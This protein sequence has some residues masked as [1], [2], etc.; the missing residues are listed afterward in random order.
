MMRTTHANIS[1]PFSYTHQHTASASTRE[2]TTT[3]NTCKGRGGTTGRPSSAEMMGE[4]VH[5]RT[6]AQKR[7]TK[8]THLAQLTLNDAHDSR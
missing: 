3:T 4:L 1:T 7:K 5:S 6:H 8:G 2:S